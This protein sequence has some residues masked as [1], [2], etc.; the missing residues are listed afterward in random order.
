MGDV[1]QIETASV[2]RT[3][4]N[5]QELFG[6]LNLIERLEVIGVLALME[7]VEQGMTDDQLRIM[8]ESMRDRFM[9]NVTDFRVAQRLTKVLRHL[10]DGEVEKLAATV[11]PRVLP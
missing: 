6:D 10:T 5:V 4:R 7:G 1:L 3:V 9:R 8:F 11:I 2:A